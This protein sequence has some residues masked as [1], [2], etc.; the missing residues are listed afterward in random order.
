MRWSV[1]PYVKWHAIECGLCMLV[2]FLNL[3]AVRAQEEKILNVYN[4]SDYI[5]LKEIEAFEAEN[6]IH[7]NYD[8]YD[9]SEIVDTK[10]MAGDSGY[11][12]VTHAGSLFSRLIPIGVFMPLD[13]SKLP[14]WKNLDA[15]VLAR[16]ALYDPGNVYSLPYMWG[17]TGFSYNVDMVL[18]RMPNAPLGSA[19]MIF[20]PEIV[21]KFA[22]C[23]VSFLDS[24]IEVISM[25][26][27]YLG[28]DPFSTDLEEMKR[29]E[30]LLK[31][32]RPYVKYYSSTRLLN[33][34]PSREVCI[35]MS[36]SGDYSN[37]AKRAEE[38]GLEI[39]LAYSVPKEGAA[40]WTESFL[41]PSDAPHPENA[42]LFLD[43]LMR[44]EVI[45]NITNEIFYANANKAS[46]PF[47]NPEIIADEAIYPS[48]QTLERLFP[49]MVL[50]PKAERNRTRT[51]A[52]VKTGM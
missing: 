29:A 24:P 27:A 13:K 20:K 8:T 31:S 17:S 40:L 21:S 34:L 50:P 4:W 7:V 41:V 2:F 43:F 14:N 46:R 1:Q 22:D 10:L 42:H 32:V 19:D 26:L 9:A 15:D 47:I 5:S 28:F 25:A 30:V 48:Q 35:A 6:G 37:A 51:W 45:A 52:R 44:P 3:T 23:G 18:E 36:W 39:N 11:D 38:A 16:I 12:V 33:D 49:T